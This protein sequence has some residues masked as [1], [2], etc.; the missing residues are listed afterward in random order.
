MPGG[1]QDLGVI[2]L[3]PDVPF[4]ATI[5]DEAT[6]APLTGASTGGTSGYNELTDADGRF[7]LRGFG[8]IASFQLNVSK[9]G[10]TGLIGRV[11][12]TDAGT[13]YHVGE[14]FAHPPIPTAQELVIP[15]RRAGV[16]DGLAVDA[17]TGAPVR[18]K[19]V[20]V[21]NF[22][23][24]PTGKV[25]L[26]GCRSDFQQAEP[27]HFHA[28]Y[29]T[30][31]EYH[32]TLSAFGY[33]DAEAL[34]PKVDDLRTVGGIVVRMRRLAEDPS[35]VDT[36]AK[37]RIS[38]IV[39]RGGVPVPG[40]WA[41][42]WAIRRPSNPVNAPVLRGRMVASDPIKSTQT[43][44][45]LDGSYALDVLFQGNWFV[46]VD[47]PGRALAQSGPI[48]MSLREDQTVDI[49]AAE[50]G[51]VVGKLN[52]VPAG[53]QGH[54]FIVAFSRSGI[55][56]EAQVATDGSF[57]LPP[58]PP[59]EYGVKVGQDAYLDAETYP[60]RNDQIPPRAFDEV[61]DP[62]KTAVRV[63]VAAGQEVGGVVLAWPD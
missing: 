43:P 13:T 50:P 17:D 60:G 53:W 5:P 61:A 27:G 39:T 35:T 24:K 2:R 10:Y 41:G 4:T 19:Q 56:A 11:E 25:V 62:W 46:V 38:G 7:T 20:I 21:G 9:E 42:L 12:V 45:Q 52:G 44:I 8:A 48:A 47:E 37:R 32:L 40:D 34:T 23:R 18:L 57:T 26:H 28:S 30:P 14:E 49:T 15:L 1:V 59:G 55:R 3:E 58:L 54:A 63:T 36:T 6:G 33:H 51:R 31:D 16:I 22:E 29:P